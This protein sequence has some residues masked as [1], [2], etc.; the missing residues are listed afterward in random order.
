MA[1]AEVAFSR[2]V[3]RG[4]AVEAAAFFLA[5]YGIGDFPD[6]GI[7]LTTEP[8]AP[9]FLTAV[10]VAFAVASVVVAWVSLTPKSSRLMVCTVWALFLVAVNFAYGPDFAVHAEAFLTISA[11]LA[12]FFSFRAYRETKLQVA[13]HVD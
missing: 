9:A 8:T 1:S 12:L 3:R 7:I 13:S 5:V 10:I 6:A 2:V 11:F 4:V